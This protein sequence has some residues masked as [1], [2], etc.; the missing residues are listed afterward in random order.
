MGNIETKAKFSR[1][2][3]ISR[4]EEYS[5]T[6]V[7]YL[8]SVSLFNYKGKLLS[9]IVKKMFIEIG[10]KKS[11]FLKGFLNLFVFGFLFTIMKKNY[12]L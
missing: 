9:F 4:I 11:E 6:L 3:S 7:T 12:D 10:L 2:K 1:L 5:F 8:F